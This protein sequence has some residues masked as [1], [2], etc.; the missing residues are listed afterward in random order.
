MSARALPAPAIDACDVERLF[1]ELDPGDA[2][3][4]VVLATLA[5]QAALWPN[6]LPDAPLPAPLQAVMLTVAARIAAS[7]STGSQEVVSE[8][9]GAY[10]YRRETG[11]VATGGL[12][13]LTEDELAALAPWSG[14]KAVY[15]LD[16]AARALGWPVE[17]WQRDLDDV[18]AYWDASTF[19]GGSDPNWLSGIKP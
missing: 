4:A 3:R 12:L 14:H 9:I 18:Q 2:E 10:S 5:V 7:S 17:W 6:E 16:V 13:W 11:A 1:P 8:S 15:E 19:P